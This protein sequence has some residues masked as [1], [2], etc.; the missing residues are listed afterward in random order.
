MKKK[1]KRI[2]L[3]VVIIAVIAFILEIFVFKKSFKEPVKTELKRS[4]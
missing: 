3:V 1:I 2:F 4:E